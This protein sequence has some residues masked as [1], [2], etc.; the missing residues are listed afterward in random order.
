MS[1]IRRKYDEESKKN[2]GK[3]SYASPKTIGEVW[4]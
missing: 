1:E 3:L 2:A 4:R